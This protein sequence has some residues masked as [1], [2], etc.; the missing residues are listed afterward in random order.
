MVRRLEALAAGEGAAD[1]ITQEYIEMVVAEALVDLAQPG[2]GDFFGRL[3]EET[4]ERWYVGRRHI[5]DDR[6]DPVVIDWRAA[7]AA[8]FYRATVHDPL[9][10]H[11]RRRFTMADGRT[12]RLS[13]RAPR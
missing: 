11:R 12:H 4:G 7:V 10:L 2:A 5:E 3:D 1:D 13:R 9:G 8:P 6:H